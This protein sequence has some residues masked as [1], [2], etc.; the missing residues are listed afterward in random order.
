ML[1]LPNT[2]TLI[3]EEAKTL[4]REYA[5]L[6]LS[7]RGYLDNPYTAPVPSQDSF[8]LAQR[9]VSEEGQAEVN[10]IFAEPP[11]A[12]YIDGK[13][14]LNINVIP[15]AD[16]QGNA[17]GNYRISLTVPKGT[18]TRGGPVTLVWPQK[19]V[20]CSSLVIR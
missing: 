12:A 16:P 14:P 1:T 10:G 18:K 3:S 2:I 7:L 6:V 5:G 13:Y 11:V 4:Q 17:K 8:D 20:L 15:S 19:T 9:E